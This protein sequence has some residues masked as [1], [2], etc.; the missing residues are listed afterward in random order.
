V[1]LTAADEAG[2]SGVEQMM[3]RVDGGA[4]Q[5]YGGPFDFTVDGEHTLEYRSVDGAGNAEDYNTPV[6]L[7]V[8]A[9]APTTTATASPSR[10]LGTEGWYDSAVELTLRARDGEGSGTA[11][12][13]YRVGDGDWQPYGE[14]LVLEEAGVHDV[15]YRSSDAA[16][17]HEEINSTRVKVD[18]TAPVTSARINGAAPQAE[19]D[20]AVRVAFT[21]TDGDGSGVVGTEYRIG[22]GAWTDYTGAFDIEGNRGHRVD[23]RSRDLA[24][25]VENFRTVAFV[26]RPGPAPAGTPPPPPKVAE[27]PKPFAAL[28]TLARSRSTIAA[29]RGGRLAVRVSCQAVAGGTLSL[30]VTRAV[31]R[32][33]GLASRVLAKRTVR[34]ADQGRASVTLEPGRKVKRA[35]ARSKGS[36][37]ATLALQMAGDA[38]KANDSAP[39]VLRAT[40]GR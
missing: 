28:G 15:D 19:Y 4:P 27:K 26:I 6:Q 5:A 12:T 30:T 17:N 22:D 35:L 20:G 11:V 21:R 13:E 38:G 16:G 32:R 39:V 10:P 34:C 8:D 2:G 18:R 36:V 24:G 31:R 9:T 33:L 25:N 3:Y 40:G 37:A 1:T 23:F 29:F 7:K 14:P